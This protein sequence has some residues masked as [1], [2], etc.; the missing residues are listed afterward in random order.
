MVKVTLVDNNIKQTLNISCYTGGV[1]ENCGEPNYDFKKEN[2][3]DSKLNKP[4]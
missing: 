2:S 1:L 3:S 4:P